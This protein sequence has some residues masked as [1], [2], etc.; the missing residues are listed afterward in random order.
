MNT[1]RIYTNGVLS[2]SEQ[3]V[4]TEYEQVWAAADIHWTNDESEGGQ[5]TITPFPNP[6][7]TSAVGAV[8]I[9]DASQCGSPAGWLF[10]GE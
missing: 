10:P 6:E 5:A 7:P 2:F 9:R 8:E 4:L 3:L 1:I